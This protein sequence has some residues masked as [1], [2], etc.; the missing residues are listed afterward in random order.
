MFRDSIDPFM[1][2]SRASQ[3]LIIPNATC[4]STS[5]GTSGRTPRSDQHVD[6]DV[7]PLLDDDQSVSMDCMLCFRDSAMLLQDYLLEFSSPSSFNFR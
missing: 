7:I 1:C 3:R 6:I 5:S 2:P 4:I